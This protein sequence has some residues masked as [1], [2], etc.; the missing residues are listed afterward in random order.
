LA[1]EDAAKVIELSVKEVLSEG[2]RTVDIFTDS[3]GEK[4]LSTIEMGDMVI[5]KIKELVH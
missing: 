3:I 1:L 5:E 4:C 2:Y